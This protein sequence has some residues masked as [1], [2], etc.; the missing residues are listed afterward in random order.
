MTETTRHHLLFGPY[1]TPI[2]KYGDVVICELRG[3]VEPDRG[4][5]S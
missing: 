1:Q 5:A 4:V 2:F 3:E